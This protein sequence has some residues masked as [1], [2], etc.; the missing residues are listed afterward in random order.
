MSQNHPANDF[1]PQ[2]FMLGNHIEYSCMTA[3]FVCVTLQL[4][5][6][7][8]PS[9]L[10]QVIIVVQIAKSSLSFLDVLF[11]LYLECKHSKLACVLCLQC[12][13]AKNICA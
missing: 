11:D 9:S 6:N 12:K 3:C 7:T 5:V 2:H 13:H 10:L 4:A 8:V 1:F